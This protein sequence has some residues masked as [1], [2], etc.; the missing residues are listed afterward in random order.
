MGIRIIIADDHRIVRQGLKVLLERE[1]GLQ[2]V[3]EAETGRRTVTLVREFLP[4]IVIMDVEMP[5]MNGIEA[6][7]QILSE[8]PHIK[9]IVLSMHSDRRFIMNMLKT[10]A[11]GYLFK[12]CAFEELVQAIRLAMA[13]RTYLSPRICK[14]VGKDRSKN[15][16]NSEWTYLPVLTSREREVLQLMSEGKRSS[17]IAKLL[18]ISS[19]T[20]DTHRQQIMAKLG[21]RSVADL[22]KFA[23]REGLT[24]LE[25]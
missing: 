2:V 24:S 7:R 5:E 9:I 13:N 3:A 22:T 21:T 10:G 18:R 14:L 6:S 1:P 11:H 19:K 16:P 8:F 23:I 25:A 15:R 12:D 17:Q 4:H 20:V